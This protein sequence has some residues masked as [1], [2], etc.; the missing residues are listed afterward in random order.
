ML[1]FWFIIIIWASASPFVKQMLICS[2]GDWAA[3]ATM[4]NAIAF[5]ILCFIGLAKGEIKIK[6]NK[7]KFFKLAFL[8]G[9][10]DIFVLL[11]IYFCSTIQYAILANYLW[12]ILLV[13]FLAK[14][15][16][17]EL[18]KSAF[19]GCVMGF[20]GVAV[21]LTPAIRNIMA[22]DIIGILFGIIAAFLWAGYSS[23]LEKEHE[24]VRFTLQG[25]AQG[26]SS[27]AAFIVGHLTK[28]FDWNNIFSVCSITLIIIFATIHMAL[29]YSLWIIV[30]RKVGQ[31]ASSSLYAI[32][33]LAL[34]ISTIWFGGAWNQL[35]W[36][37]SILV[38]GGIF[39]SRVGG[40]SEN[41]KK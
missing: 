32:P 4:Y 27:I 21:I 15:R 38:I 6:I 28:T 39:A 3:V 8:N 14:S 22:E 33:I 19:I 9:F 10:Y 37:A 35:L 26:I 31:K 24:K 29:S 20:L 40:A 18:S 41:N 1:L 2:N 16:G 13:I 34:V 30:I 25:V 17:E 23:L 7:A 11:A 36:V 5:F 12:P